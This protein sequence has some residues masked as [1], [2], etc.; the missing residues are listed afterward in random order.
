MLATFTIFGVEM[1]VA[2]LPAPVYKPRFSVDRVEDEQY[3]DHIIR[4]QRMEITVSRPK[5]LTNRCQR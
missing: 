2:T 3:T 5:P 1:C 4:I